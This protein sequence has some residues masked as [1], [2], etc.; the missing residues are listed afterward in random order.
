MT[1]EVEIAG[2]A[3]ERGTPEQIDRL[4][5]IHTEIIAHDADRDYEA[6]SVAGVAFHRQL[7]VMAGNDLFLLLLDSIG[8][9]LLEVRRT[10][11]SQIGA[12]QDIVHHENILSAIAARDPQAARRA[13][14]THLTRAYDD[15]R[16]HGQPVDLSHLAPRTD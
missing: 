5:E 12:A 14:A 4:R 3:A 2:L 1:I 7:A 9:I 6:R 8:D 11:A 13:M 15:W 10:T 16:K